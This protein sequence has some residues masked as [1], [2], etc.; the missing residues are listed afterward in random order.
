MIDLFFAESLL[1]VQSPVVWDWTLKS[2]AT[3]FRGDVA[4]NI[5]QGFPP[6]CANRQYTL[7]KAFLLPLYL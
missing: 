3:Q 4:A 2:V 6:R 1:H 7:A 5:R